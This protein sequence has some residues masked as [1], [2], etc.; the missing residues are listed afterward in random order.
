MGDTIW[1]A[2]QA[3]GTMAIVIVLA[4]LSRK[5]TRQMLAG[6]WPRK[7]SALARA[8]SDPQF[9]PDPE[10]TDPFHVMN[11]PHE[12]ALDDRSQAGPTAGHTS[13]AGGSREHEQIVDRAHA[14]SVEHPSAVEQLDGLVEPMDEVHRDVDGAPTSAMSRPGLASSTSRS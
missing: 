7:P 10:V 2:L 11:A 6:R 14:A 1:L 5:Q 4:L 13:R 3:F 8:T 9:Q 12:S